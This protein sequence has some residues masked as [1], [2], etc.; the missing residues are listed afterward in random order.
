MK[1]SVRD[2]VVEANPSIKFGEC[3]RQLKESSLTDM[4]ILMVSMWWC[5]RVPKFLRPIVKNILESKYG[6]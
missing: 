3:V 5:G 1:I 2:F 6:S 4:Q